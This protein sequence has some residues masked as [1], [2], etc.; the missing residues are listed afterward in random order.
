VKVF[1]AT[2]ETRYPSIAVAE[3]AEDAIRL[4]AD[5]ALAF[6][7]EAQATMTGKTDTVEGVVEYF[8]VTAEEIELNTAKFEKY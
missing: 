5:H 6:L 4:A 1:I 8:A 7:K 2:V 3:T